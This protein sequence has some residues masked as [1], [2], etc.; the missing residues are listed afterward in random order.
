[1]L[2]ALRL[3]CGDTG[4]QAVARTIEV[5]ARERVAFHMAEFEA[6]KGEIA[7]LVKQTGTCLTFAIT[8]VGGITAWLLAHTEIIWW[9]RWLP[10]AVS[11]LFGC[12]AGSYYIRIGQKGDYLRKLELKLGADG[13]GWQGEL[14]D[15]PKLIAVM[16]SLCWGVLN[17][18][19]IIVAASPPTA[20]APVHCM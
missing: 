2:F 9:G 5:T 10:L 12:L 16:H 3:R 1:M 13:L 8:T 7:E 4:G 20:P 6:L 19:G 17:T 11:A 15:Q 18:I 14:N